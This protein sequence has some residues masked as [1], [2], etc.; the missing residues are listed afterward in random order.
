MSELSFDGFLKSQATFSEC[1]TYRYQL[2]RPSTFFGNGKGTLMW[3]ML[4]PSTADQSADDPTIRKC[5]GFTTRLGY[6]KLAVG[7]LFAYRATDPKHLA[8]AIV[9]NGESHAVG[10]W[11]DR[12]LAKM[13]AMSTA[14][15]CGWG[16]HGSKFA[17]RVKVVTNIVT[18][19]GVPMLR[20]GPLTK[21][22]HPRHPLYVS[23]KAT[24]FL[25]EVGA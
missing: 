7:N 25:F 20:L 2:W 24:P 16:A 11:N 6:S 12:E 8:T 14:A 13:L 10:K 15:V 23:Y 4:N 18:H 19:S 5:I 3:I 9:Q 22:G 1:G 17:D 21:D